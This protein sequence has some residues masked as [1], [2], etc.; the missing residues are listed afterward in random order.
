[1][2]SALESAT[3]A[4]Q[5]GGDRRSTVLT[6]LEDWASSCAAWIQP[7]TLGRGLHAQAASYW[8]SG[9]LFTLI[10]VAVERLT[11]VYKLD[12]LGITL[13]GP[14]AGLSLVVLLRKGATFAPFIFLASLIADFAVYDGPRGIFAPIGTSIVL[15]V[16]FVAVAT[17]LRRTSRFGE[18][19]PRLADVVAL[20]AIVPIGALLMAVLYCAVLLASDLLSSWRFVIAA[21]N[22]WIGDTLGM[23]TLTAAAP[24]V[25]ALAA[26]PPRTVTRSQIADIGG[27]AIALGAALW[28]IFAVA[29]AQEYQFFYLL[30]LP[31]VWIA[32]RAG[33]TAVSIALLF[34]HV[35]LVTIATALGY[36]A[37]DFIA[38]QMLMLVLSAT[39]LLLGAVVTERR[40]SAERI[41]SQQAE[42]A[43]IGR[44]AT[45][46]AMG[47]AMAHEISQ[48][49][50][51][52]TNYLHAA[53]RLLGSSG[54]NTGQVGEALAKAELEARRA[55]EA[56]ERVRDYVSSGRV[57]LRDVNLNDLASRM[58][59]VVRG[60][61][62]LRGVTVDVAGTPHLPPVQADAIQI[63]QLLLNLISNAIDAAS[64]RE[65]RNGHV[66]I[67]LRQRVDRIVVTVE[68]NGPGMA[69]DIAERLFEPFETTKPK[70]MGLGLTIAR[71][72]VET[73]GGR[74]RWERMEPQ[75]T[76]FV[77]ELCI[78]GPQRHAV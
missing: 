22:F 51:S 10:Y 57:E 28:I 26:S 24:S 39:G 25:I 16:G 37:Y 68:D 8:L 65:D 47:T 72:I 30:F 18:G 5:N 4:D 32:I 31:I 1:L 45:V 52:A 55:R 19:C 17:M 67:R 66:T 71:Q 60:D 23:I 62:A 41:R 36:A 43:R 38:F 34:T 11:L 21:R 70:G 74:I 59:L 58:A 3:I 7:R 76:R 27:F 13:W 56:L 63:E 14:A 9:F 64:L 69:E 53:H 73:H 75:G 20:L 2:Q 33:Y 15:A 12:G 6:R 40:M 42:L 35:V 49:L 54:G 46:G 77:V 48:P 50:A 29:S 44:H 61:A 78:D